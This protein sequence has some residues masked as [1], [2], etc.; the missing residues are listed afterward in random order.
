MSRASK[1]E[2]LPLLIVVLNNGGYRG[3]RNTRSP[4]TPTARAR[5]TRF[6]SANARRPRYEDSRQAVRRGRHRID[7]AAKLR[8]EWP[9]RGVV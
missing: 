7:Q 5:S 1:N 2:K 3:M 6:S 9:R 8:K 4:I